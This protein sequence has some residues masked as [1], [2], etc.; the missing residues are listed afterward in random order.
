MD[1]ENV[2]DIEVD[3][4]EAKEGL[5]AYEVYL[6]NGGT[7]SE[8]EWLES[9]RGDTGPTGA[10]GIDGKDGK[11][12][13]SAYESWLD[14]GNTG[15]EEDFINSLKGEK[16][17]TPDLTDY[18]KIE[19]VVEIQNNVN[20]NKNNIKELQERI[21]TIQ[22]NSILN[23]N[24]NTTREFT[25]QEIEKLFPFAKYCTKN[26]TKKI[27]LVITGLDSISSVDDIG[28]LILFTDNI[29]IMSNNFFI[30]LSAP[31]HL[32]TKA[33]A[34][35]IDIITC[36]INGTIS[37]NEV[38]SINSAKISRRGYDIPLVNDVLTKTN[39]ASFTP[40]SDYHPATKK[41]VDDSISYAIT[42]ALGGSY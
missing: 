21:F 27:I 20:E 22:L 5:S 33:T 38:I 36:N 8:E 25:S 37:N 26:Q 42:D 4:S 35:R 31:Y 32:S 40:T 30:Q 12:G 34:N 13:K 18:A 3:A 23:I 28:G 24:M 1:I 10:N 2:I 39:T 14:A 41:Y 17:D 6:K 15:T 16:G 9:L 29:Q 7:L 19:Y 11:D